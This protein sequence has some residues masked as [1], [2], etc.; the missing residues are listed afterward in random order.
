[1]TLGE[2]M[3]E[4]LQFGLTLC[5]R[6][7]V[8]GEQSADQL[9]DLAVAAEESGQFDSVW[10][11]DSLFVNRRLDS[12][13][14]LAAIAGRTRRVLLG[15][16][17]MGSF[18][19][20]NALTLA[21]EWA[22]LDQI[23]NGRT[24]LIAC[25]G[26][27]AGPLW[28]AEARALAVDPKRRRRRLVEHMD[29]IRQLWTEVSVTY[30]SEAYSFHGLTVE[31]KPVQNPCPIW[32]ATN[33]QRLSSGSTTPSD[34]GLRRV[35]E[36]ADGWMTH[37]TTPEQFADSWQMIKE[38]AVARGRQSD[39]FD[40]CLYHNINVGTD[41]AACLTEASSFLNAYYETEFSRERTQAW[42]TYGTPDECID[43]LRRWRGS[44]LQ[45]VTVR[46]AS[47]DQFGQFDR[48]VN[49]VLPY[50]NK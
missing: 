9:I 7:V 22:S 23:S 45:R 47:F 32:L 13:T 43:D 20:R 26:G 50:V 2:G 12:I 33:A 6:G 11:G 41:T 30:E 18:A 4:S 28:E 3:F 40:N 15:P 17:C 48:L 37:S 16:A 39:R 10:V 21:Y 35:A 24:R 19:L 14:L 5:N 49:D 34:A 27:G 1:V 25:T 44:G 29:I 8:T 36:L 42:C 31:P 38:I 46:L